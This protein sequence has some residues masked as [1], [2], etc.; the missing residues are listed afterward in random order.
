[1]HLGIIFQASLTILRS[2]CSIF[3][4]DMNAQKN[5]C[6]YCASSKH[7]AKG[8]YDAASRLGQL[9]AK[10][11]MAC[12]CGAGREGLMGTLADS[13]LANGGSVTGVIPEFMVDNGWCHQSLTRTIVT[14][15]I[16]SRKR[17]MAEM[18]DAAVAL[19]GGCGTLEELLE[20]ITWKQLGLYEKPV[21]ILNTGG[22]YDPLLQMLSN[23]AK[24]HFMKESHLRL[25]HMAATPED[26]MEIL[27][28][29]NE[30]SPVESKYYD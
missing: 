8:Y 9:L 3:A 6:I 17:R 4:N 10:S 5:I 20:I 14:P 29:E 1:M 16:H 28:S 24:E 2:I 12:V 7:I 23:A 21:I 11:G 25:W 15:D 30:E 27:L 13:V 19:P 18:S 22:Y 26:V